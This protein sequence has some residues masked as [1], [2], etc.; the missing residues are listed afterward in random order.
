MFE[1]KRW[2]RPWAMAAAAVGFVMVVVYL[3]LIASQGDASL[4]VLPWALLM[5]LAAVGALISARLED[6][7]ASRRIMIGSAILFG[8]LGIASALT[9]GIGFVVGAALLVV[10][11][12]RLARSSRK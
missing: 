4:Q 12:N 6:A 2:Q 9:I 8:L 1:W 5:S 11:S 7:D 3:T 10:A